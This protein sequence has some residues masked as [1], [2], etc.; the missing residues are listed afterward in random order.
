VL[1]GWL[2]DKSSI[3]KTCAMQGIAD[4]TR[5]DPTLRDEVLD[6]LRALR[7][8]GTPA[9]RARGRILIEQLEKGRDLIWVRRKPQARKATRLLNW[10]D[11]RSPVRCHG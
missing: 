9:M 10:P 2:D 11:K 6:L 3:V 4:L 8:S 5:Q 7:R 1:Q